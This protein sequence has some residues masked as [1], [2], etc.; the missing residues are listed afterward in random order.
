[1]L[2][3]PFLGGKPTEQTNIYLN[4][5]ITREIVAFQQTGTKGKVNFKYLNVGSYEL[6]AEFPQQEGKYIKEKR[7]YNTLTVSSYNPKNKTY[8]YQ[9]Y[10]GYFSVKFSGL[11]KIPK[12]SIKAVFREQRG[13][14]GFKVVLSEFKAINNGANIT[15]SVKTLTAAQFK[16]ATDK[17]KDLAIESIP[18]NW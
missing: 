5:I 3:I 15:V 1:L 12:E 18:A 2:V 17:T 16:R 8:Y 10:E 4:S 9:S 14:E 11:K 7:K 13:E 6:I